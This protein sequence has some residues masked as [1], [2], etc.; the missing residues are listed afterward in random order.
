VWRAGVQSH[1]SD[2]F[3]SISRNKLHGAPFTKR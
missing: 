3:W 2:F 1:Q